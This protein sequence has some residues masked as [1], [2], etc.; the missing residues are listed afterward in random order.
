[1]RKI[2]ILSIVFFSLCTMSAV[3]Q[4]GPGQF[5][6]YFKTFRNDMNGYVKLFSP[7]V[8][9]ISVNPTTS[10]NE[11]Q[12]VSGA[13]YLKQIGYMSGGYGIVYNDATFEN[14]TFSV[15]LNTTWANRIGVLYNYKDSANFCSFHYDVKEENKNFQLFELQEGAPNVGS[16]TAGLV[17]NFSEVEGFTLNNPNF[18]FKVKNENGKTTAWLNNVCIF[19]SLPQAK[20]ALGKIGV[21]G[22][23]N[24]QLYVD[25]ILVESNFGKPSSNATLSAITA[26][27]GSITPEIS[28]SVIN[29][30][31]SVPEGTAS[32]TLGGITSDAGASVAGGGEITTIPSVQKMTVTA[33]DGTKY[34][35]TVNIS[36]AV[37]IDSKNEM[38]FSVYPNPA[39]D[40]IVIRLQNDSKVTISSIV[41]AKVLE[42]YSTNQMLE[43][44]I[45]GLKQ[46]LYYITVDDGRGIKT[47]K[48]LKR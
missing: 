47:S 20:Y 23:S 33:A 11:L 26:S 39:N 15:K 27:V 24:N 42:A 8:W 31:L 41:G 46:G 22:V 25:S 28:A 21:Y 19:N 29:Y 38:N 9:T 3:A 14:Y 44:D 40:F 6:S 45:S 37:G 2:F 35:Y 36:V 4:F 5:A 7:N 16:R 13:S 10:V 32:V 48:L 18:Y 30:S 34:T 12:Q 17:R 43:M 1:M